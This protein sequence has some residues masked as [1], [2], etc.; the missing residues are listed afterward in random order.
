MKYV[1]NVYAESA[2]TSTLVHARKTMRVQHLLQSSLKI[3]TVQVACIL[4]YNYGE[5]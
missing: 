3:C 5:Q 4:S 2:D 1:Y